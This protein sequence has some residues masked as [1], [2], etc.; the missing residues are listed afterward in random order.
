VIILP[1][2]QDRFNSRGASQ[3]SSRVFNGRSTRVDG[4][5]RSRYRSRER[6]TCRETRVTAVASGDS[7]VHAT[8]TDT[9]G[10]FG[11]RFLPPARY[12][13]VAFDD[14]NR[15]KKLDRGERRDTRSIIV[16]SVRD[17]QVVELALLAPDT[18]PARLLRAEPRDSMEVRLV[19]DDY[20]E[21][22]Q[23]LTGIRVQ[24]F[25]LPDSTVVPGATITTQEA[26]EAARARR[27]ALHAPS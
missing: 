16:A 12:D 20:L 18:T 4:D 26:A 11:L 6:A 1:G 23:V 15:N 3:L 19:F 9:A 5:R 13:V 22:K 10:F 7:V 24:L 21:P 17:T 25:Q 2:I 14:Q 8:V 27:I